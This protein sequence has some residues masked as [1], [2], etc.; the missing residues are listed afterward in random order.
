MK[1]T[2]RTTLDDMAL[3][4]KGARIPKLH[5]TVTIGKTRLGRPPHTRYCIYQTETHTVLL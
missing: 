2:H 3:M 5:G 1:T 4:T